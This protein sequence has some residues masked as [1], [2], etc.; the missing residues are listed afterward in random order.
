MASRKIYIARHGERLDFVDPSWFRKSST[1]HDPPLTARGKQQATELGHKLASLDIKHVFA[2]PFSRCVNTAS[3]AATEISPD[4]KVNIEPGLCEWLNAVWYRHSEKGPIWR[5]VDSLAAEFSNVDASYTPV[6]PMSHNFDGFPE[7]LEKLNRRCDKTYRA[8]LEMVEGDGNVLLVGHGTSVDS[9]I[10]IL[11]P[12][13]P[14][15][16]ITYCCLTECIPTSK[17]FKYKVGMH[18]DVSFL[19][20]PEDKDD[21]RYV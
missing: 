19:S 20:S 17:E 11:A 18:C 16:P 8:V 10:K 7:S 2:S 4:L 5:T 3:N 21:T 13:A 1:P 6:Y 12:D 9:L 14:D 15:E